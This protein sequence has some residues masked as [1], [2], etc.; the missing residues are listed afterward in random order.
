MKYQV[1]GSCGHT[2]TTQLFGPGKNREYWL[3]R[4]AGEPCDE[5][6]EAARKAKIEKENTESAA[7][8]LDLGLPELTGSPK[9]VA[10][11]ESIRKNIYTAFDKLDKR[12]T[13]RYGDGWQYREAWESF[14]R[15]VFLNEE[16][17]WY[18][19]HQDNYN[20]YFIPDRFKEY[21]A[22]NK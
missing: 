12:V 11:A 9:Q 10:W 22:K 4:L 14:R 6:K 18:I 13:D 8:A 20:E 16:A 21:L 2:Y 19:E 5:C 3:G 17:K 15:E 7:W 1:T